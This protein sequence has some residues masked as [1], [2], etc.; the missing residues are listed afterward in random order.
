MQ[1]SPDAIPE[2]ETPHTVTLNAYDEM[3]DVCRPGDRIKITGKSIA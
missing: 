2:G 1:E 3:V